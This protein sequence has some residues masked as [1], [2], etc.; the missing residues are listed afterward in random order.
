M[1]YITRTSSIV[2]VDA[3]CL[4][5]ALQDLGATQVAVAQNQVSFTLNGTGH[6]VDRL[7]NGALQWT[8]RNQST[9]QSLEQTMP[10]VVEAYQAVQKAREEARRKEQQRLASLQARLAELGNVSFDGVQHEELATESAAIQADI[11]ATQQ[12]LGRLEAEAEAFEAS[13]QHYLTTTKELVEEKA[14]SNNWSVSAM[15]EDRVKR[16]TRIQLRRK[17]S[18]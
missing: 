12:E 9:F 10:R 11:A 3:S 1:S 7:R 16:Q 18:N 8:S 6:R 14:A 17:V 4:T 2:M 13:R 5:E 15:Q